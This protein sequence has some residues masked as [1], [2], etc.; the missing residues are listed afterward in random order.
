MFPKFGPDHATTGIQQLQF[1]H[2]WLETKKVINQYGE[3]QNGFSEAAAFCHVTCRYF[4]RF[5]L[6]V[7]V[8]VTTG[9]GFFPCSNNLYDSE[10]FDYLL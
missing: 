10:D 9:L 4:N 3:N 5:L 6:Q 7:G 8:Q 1:Y 2:K